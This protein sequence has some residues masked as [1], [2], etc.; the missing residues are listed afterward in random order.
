VLLKSFESLQCDHC[1]DK[2]RL[3]DPAESVKLASRIMRRRAHVRACARMMRVRAWRV[4]VARGRGVHGL[5][6]A[7]PPYV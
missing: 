1:I 4:R 5:A 3:A 2:S 6:I 7:G